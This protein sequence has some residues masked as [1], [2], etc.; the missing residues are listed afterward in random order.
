MNR[1][2]KKYIE[3]D[4]SVFVISSD[5]CH[6]GSSFRFQYYN[7]DDGE[8]WRSIE[9]LDRLGARYFCDGDADGFAEYIER[10]HNT[11]CGRNC[12]EVGSLRS[13][14][15]IDYVKSSKGKWF[16]NDFSHH[17]VWSKCS[18]SQLQR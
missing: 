12:I 14:D 17:K 5:F 15:C 2:L 16:D 10:Y 4:E 18:S 11:I 3:D 9:K 1:V 7:P 8:I 13:S 6:W